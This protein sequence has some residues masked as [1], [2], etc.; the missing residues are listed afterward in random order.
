MASPDLTARSPQVPLA[1]LEPVKTCSLTLEE[2][3]VD[4]TK[5]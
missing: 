2:G 4:V 5:K 3:S 1:A